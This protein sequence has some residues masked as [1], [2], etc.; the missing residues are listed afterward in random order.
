MLNSKGIIGIIVRLGLLQ[1]RWP[2][3]ACKDLILD[4]GLQLHPLTEHVA[5]I[6]LIDAALRGEFHGLVPAY[7][8]H[9]VLDRVLVVV[10]I[11]LR[12]NLIF[13]DLRLLVLLLLLFFFCFCRLLY[14]LARQVKQLLVLKLAVGQFLM[15]IGTELRRLFFVFRV[16]FEH[17]HILIDYIVV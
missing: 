6:A 4:P 9:V 14:Q 3:P 13:F 2:C 8:H 1:L 11:R 10:L 12:R 15:A 16:D 5:A 17:W 7:L